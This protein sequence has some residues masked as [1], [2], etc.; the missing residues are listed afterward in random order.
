MNRFLGDTNKGKSD[1]STD[2]P[3]VL[4]LFEFLLQLVT[5]LL[6]QLRDRPNLETPITQ[7]FQIV[8]IGGVSLKQFL[9]LRGHL[10]HASTLATTTYPE[11]LNTILV[12]NSGDTTCAPSVNTPHSGCWGP[13]FRRNGLA[14]HSSMVTIPSI[15]GP[16]AKLKTNEQV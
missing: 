6:T 10:G 3:A 2:P 12:S 11:T 5:P 7:S 4:A 15:V 16:T 9:S 1:K 13:P 14:I 8:D